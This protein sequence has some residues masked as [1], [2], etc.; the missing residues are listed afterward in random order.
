MSATFRVMCPRESLMTYLAAGSVFQE[1]LVDSSDNDDYQSKLDS[2]VQAWTSAE[3]SSLADVEGFVKWFL[4]N[5]ADAI[6]DTML[7]PIR[8]ECGLGNPPDPFTTNASES[9]NAMLKRKVSYKQSELPAFIDHV[10]Q[11]INEQEKEVERAVIKRGKYRFRKQYRFLEVEEGKWFTMSSEQRQRHLAKVQSAAVSDACEPGVEPADGAGSSLDIQCGRGNALSKALS[12][13]VEAAV[14]A[15]NLPLTCVERMWLKAAELIHKEHA[16]VPAPGQSPEAKMVLSYS[17]KSPHMVTPIKGGGFSCD[18]NCANWK[19]LGICSHSIAVA[20][21]NG[22]LSEFVAFVQKKKKRPNITK[23]TTASMP[24]GRGRKGGVPPRKRKAPVHGEPTRL[25]MSTRSSGDIGQSMSSTSPPSQESA[26]IALSPMEY[27][28]HV[29]ASGMSTVT[30]HNTYSPGSLW[31]AYGCPSTYTYPDW[32]WP[33]PSYSPWSWPNLGLPPPTPPS[34]MSSSPLSA[35]PEPYKVCFK[36]GNIAVCN[37]C[38]NTFL[39][40]DKIVI[41][42]PEFRQFI[43]PRTGLPSSK[44]GIAYYHTRRKCIELKWGVF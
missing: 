11:L 33:P 39:D 18:S 24:K 30:T 32:R 13:N 27:N 5:K 29:N 1:G 17:G 43:S 9:I 15:V 28:T 31:Q 7:R 26:G 6:R 34:P 4:T 3:V 16:I 40:A 38:R 41:Q 23:L 25:P 14:K 10:K 44:Y 42:H 22:K 2:L 36:V 12:V 8:V 35:P 21:I 19:S 20:E 37:G